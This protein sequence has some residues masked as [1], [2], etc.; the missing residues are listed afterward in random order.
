MC[1]IR[2]IGAIGIKRWKWASEEKCYNIQPTQ[3]SE[4][5]SQAATCHIQQE[6]IKKIQLLKK[7]EATIWSPDIR[8]CNTTETSTRRKRIGQHVR[9]NLDI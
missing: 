5:S 9:C 2:R 1:Q 3:F 4:C 6:S 8:D 7:A